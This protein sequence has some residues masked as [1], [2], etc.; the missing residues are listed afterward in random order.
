[1]G[2]WAGSKKRR[3]QVLWLG[4]NQRPPR[5]GF[6]GSRRIPALPHSVYLSVYRSFSI[7]RQ[8]GLV[9][10]GRRWVCRVCRGESLGQAV[11]GDSAACALCGWMAVRDGGGNAGEQGC[12]EAWWQSLHIRRRDL[13]RGC[14]YD[15]G[16]LASEMGHLRGIRCVA[17]PTT[18][19]L[20][21]QLHHQN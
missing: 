17:V 8:A 7:G 11:W 21:R 10:G 18:V 6:P 13:K 19:P 9:V 3:V 16:I 15:D 2:G 4:S 1:M 12:R 14:C 20:S 5:P